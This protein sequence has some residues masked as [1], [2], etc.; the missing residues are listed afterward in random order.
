MSSSNHHRSSRDPRTRLLPPSSPN[1]GRPHQRSA[2]QRAACLAVRERDLE[3]DLLRG[4]GKINN[5]QIASIPV[6]GAQAESHHRW[7]ENANDIASERCGARRCPGRILPRMVRKVAETR[8]VALPPRTSAL[9]SAP[10][11]AHFS[12]LPL[13]PLHRRALNGDEGLSSAGCNWTN[14]ARRR[15]GMT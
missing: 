15:H 5:C 4:R 14:R 13:S 12:P 10:A 8:P 6:L 1:D 3:R 7:N 9:L 2:E 11:T